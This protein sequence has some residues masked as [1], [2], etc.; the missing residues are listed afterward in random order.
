MN[1]E[2]M[3]VRIG[4]LEKWPSPDLKRRMQLELDMELALIKVGSEGGLHHFLLHW[5]RSIIQ[6]ILKNRKAS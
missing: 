5:D 4:D 3:T 1:V 6:E 2:G